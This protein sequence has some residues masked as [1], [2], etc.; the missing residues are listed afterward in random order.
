MTETAVAEPAET[1]GRMSELVGH[2]PTVSIL[3]SGPSRTGKTSAANLLADR[4]GI[5]NVKIGE[6]FRKRTGIDT[7]M[8]VKR[9]PAIDREM[10]ALQADMIRTATSADPFILEARLSAFLASKER[11]DRDLP[12]VTV[13]FWAP[14]AVRMER[15]LRKIRRDQPER[16]DTLDDLVRGERERVARDL[17]LWK[18]VHPELDDRNVFDPDLTDPNGKPVYDL[19]ID[20]RIGMPD[21]CA[22]YVHNWLVDRGDI[23]SIQPEAS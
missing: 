18:S 3:I 11:G 16:T 21:V 19:V 22:H 1:P 20:T 8:F 7:G 6:E 9:D 4:Y 15:Q 5:R 2:R 14:E 17:E 13:L 10:D 12:V 23:D